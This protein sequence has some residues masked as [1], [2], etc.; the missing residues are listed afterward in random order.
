MYHHFVG[1]SVQSSGC[2][3]LV[4]MHRG[5]DKLVVS[6]IILASVFCVGLNWLFAEQVN[7]SIAQAGRAQQ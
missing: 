1:S 6:S 4:Q 7:I 3:L 5:A 2:E